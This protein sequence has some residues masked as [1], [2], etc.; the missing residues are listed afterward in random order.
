MVR[1]EAVKEEL[2][3]VVFL[4]KVLYAFSHI[5]LTCCQ[6]EEVYKFKEH[7]GDFIVPQA[8]HAFNSYFHIIIVLGFIL[9]C[10]PHSLA[11]KVHVAV[12][13]VDNA[14][15]VFGVGVAYATT[16]HYLECL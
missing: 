7:S 3:K 4:G 9:C 10:F 8:N 16:L 1:A 12:H 13:K 5:L 6:C 11:D 14:V 2:V 15:V